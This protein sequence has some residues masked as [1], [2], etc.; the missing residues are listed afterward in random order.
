KRRLLER[1]G[2][3]CKKHCDDHAQVVI[4]RDCAVDYADDYKR[5]KA[6]GPRRFEDEQ[7]GHEAC[8]ERNAS[9]AQQEKRK[10]GRKAERLKAYASVVGNLCSFV[11]APRYY[12]DHGERAEIDDDVT[13]HVKSYGLPISRDYPHKRIAR[14]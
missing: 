13:Q 14:V 9:E 10:R 7:L 11:A 3:F 5:M 8:G 6:T 12:F 2:R 4:P 1:C